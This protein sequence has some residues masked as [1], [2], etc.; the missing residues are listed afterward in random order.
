MVNAQPVMEGG[1]LKGYRLKPG[2]DRKLFSSVGLQ[3]GDIVTNVNGIP[4]NDMSQMGAVFEQLSS[5]NRLDVT[6]ER[7]GQQ[8]QLSVSLE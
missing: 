6:V 3:P 4:L 8:T 7:G 2:R 5:A 1:Q